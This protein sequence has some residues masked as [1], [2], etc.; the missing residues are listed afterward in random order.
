[1]MDKVPS[2]NVAKIRLMA[3]REDLPRAIEK[4]GRIEVIPALELA[5]LESDHVTRNSL[6][7]YF[8]PTVRGRVMVRHHRDDWEAVNTL[9]N[10]GGMKLKSFEVLNREAA[11]K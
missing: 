1:M 3:I 2:V 6:F 9:L 10:E 4:L 8:D 7:V 5:C 11:A